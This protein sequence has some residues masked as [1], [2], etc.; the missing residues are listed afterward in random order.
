MDSDSLSSIYQYITN[1][2]LPSK[3]RRTF[4][5]DKIDYILSSNDNNNNTNVT[6]IQRWT[7]QT[8]K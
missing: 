5:D 4:C 8:L 6:S 3:D 7:Q 2:I 1:N